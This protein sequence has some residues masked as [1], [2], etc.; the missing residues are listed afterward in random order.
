MIRVFSNFSVF[1]ITAVDWRD[2]GA[3][4]AVRTQGDCGACWA[5]TAVETVESA[6]YMST[7]T[8]YDLAEAEIIAC[9][10]TCEM[11]NGGWPQN[12]F[13][14]V[15]EYGGLPLQNSFPYDGSSLS[16]MTA[17]IEGTSET[18]T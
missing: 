12:A 10:D 16:G 15:M 11:C 1:V 2:S 9:D 5:I 18:W 8:L 6:H 14:W 7:G 13:E 3:V 17:G 4:S